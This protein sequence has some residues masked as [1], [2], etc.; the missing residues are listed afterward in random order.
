MYIVKTTSF[1]VYKLSPDRK[2]KYGTK[3]IVVSRFNLLFVTHLNLVRNII[4]L[5]YAPAV[6]I[7]VLRLKK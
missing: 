3:N 5:R 1:L 6:Y 7:P 4:V 2:A